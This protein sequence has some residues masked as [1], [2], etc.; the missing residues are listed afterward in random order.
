M[1]EMAAIFMF[2]WLIDPPGTKANI[3]IQSLQV[4]DWYLANTEQL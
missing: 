4:I 3:F 2:A 1:K